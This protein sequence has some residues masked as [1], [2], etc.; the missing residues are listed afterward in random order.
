MDDIQV[1]LGEAIIEWVEIG[2]SSSLVGQTLQAAD[3]HE[4]TGVSVI[5]IQRGD[6]TLPN[7]TPDTTIKEADILVT[8]GNRSEQQV[9]FS[10]CCIEFAACSINSRSSSWFDSSDT[11][12]RCRTSP[13][14]HLVT[15]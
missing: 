12:N 4:Q 5:A 3:I 14:S 11:T 10:R 13:S 9:S 1:P 8:L 7:P 2:S 6:E 15:A